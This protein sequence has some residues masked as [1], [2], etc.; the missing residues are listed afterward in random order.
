MDTLLRIKSDVP[1]INEERIMRNLYRLH[2]LCSPGYGRACYAAVCLIFTGVERN[3]YIISI[4]YKKI[5]KYLIFILRRY[6]LYN[7]M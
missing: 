2:H 5:L 3:L 6:I 4:Y 1:C 7:K